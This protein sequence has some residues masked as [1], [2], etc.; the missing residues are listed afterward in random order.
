M[1]TAPSCAYAAVCVSKSTQQNQI[2]GKEVR[3]KKRGKEFNDT[4]ALLWPIK[5]A[6]K[7]IR[8]KGKKGSG[9]K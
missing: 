9:A 1:N 4:V 5:N 3:K 2:E 6:E 8:I 7:A